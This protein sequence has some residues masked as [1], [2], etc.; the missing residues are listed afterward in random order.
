MPAYDYRCQT[1]GTVF[2]ITQRITAPAGADCPQ[3]GGSTCT[4]LITGGTFHLKGSGWYASDYGGKKG[5]EA[6]TGPAPATAPG[7]AADGA[8]AAATPAA[9]VAEA[10]A[11]P[12]ADPS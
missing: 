5:G 1:C 4:R 8:T 10:K 2:E 6:G 9:P 11:A 12:T 3:C 7:P